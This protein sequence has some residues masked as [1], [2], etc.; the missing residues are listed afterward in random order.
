MTG[1][2]ILKAFRRGLAAVGLEAERW[3]PYWLRHS[4]ITYSLDSL[5]DSELLMLAGH[6]NL[7]TNA[8][9]RHP[10]DE[11]VLKRSKAARE[12]LDKARK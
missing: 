7:I 10:D 12:K 6:T 1:A 9:Y 11:I 4:F 3:T 2:G 8:I 5:E